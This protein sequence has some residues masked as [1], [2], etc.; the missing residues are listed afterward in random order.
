MNGATVEGGLPG[1]D[2][3]STVDR[4]ILSRLQHVTAEVDQHFEVF[5]FAKVCDVLYH[6]AWDDVCDWYVELAKPVLAAGGEAAA[7]T[8]RVLG[9]VLDRLLRLLHPI[10][11]FV[12]D[13]LW[14]ALTG[15]QSVVRASWPAVD[16]AYVD[17]AAEETLAAL[18]LVVTEIRRF[19]SDQGLR[20]GQRVATRLGGLAG[21]GLAV[22][23]PLIRALARLDAPGDDFSVSASLSVAGGVGVE[24]DTRGTIDLAAERNRLDKD[25]AAAEKEIA[26]CRSKLN[27][28]AFA[29]KAPADVVAKIRERLAAAEG[30]LAR[31]TAALAALG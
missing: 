27:N 1:H 28:P 24:L 7:A 18:Q 21:T 30:D 13:E 8:R 16:S 29:D 3:L 2:Q 9:H 23:E 19:R 25:R 10:V 12:T 26:Q 20:P 15:E 11:P 5:E 17:D 6:F 4:W 22:H 31:I 14:S